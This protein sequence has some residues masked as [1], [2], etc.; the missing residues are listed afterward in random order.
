HTVRKVAGTRP[1][2]LWLRE[3]AP[4]PQ[5]HGASRGEHRRD[6]SRTGLRR[7]GGRLSGLRD[8]QRRRARRA[9]LADKWPLVR[10]LRRL[11]VG[12]ELHHDWRGGRAALSGRAAPADPHPRPEARPPLAPSPARPEAPPGP[13]TPRA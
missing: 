5:L 9:L 12:R 8:D 11:S 1:R 6:L 7:G 4:V 3:G 10:R 2:E 13:P